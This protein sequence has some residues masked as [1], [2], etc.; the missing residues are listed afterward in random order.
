MSMTLLFFSLG[1]VLALLCLWAFWLAPRLGP[2]R[3]DMAQ[4]SAM[5]ALHTLTAVAI[6]SAGIFYLEEQQW[7]PRLGL[8]LKADA[9]LVP[10]S[11]P[12]SAVIQVAIEITNKT[13]TAQTINH[14]EVS[15]D[16]LR[17]TVRRDPRSPQDVGGVEI[18][19]F[20]GSRP[21]EIGADET[22]HQFVEIPVS[23]E[24]KLVR[25]T[26]YVPK[27]GAGNARTGYERK[28]LVSL[29]DICPKPA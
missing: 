21:V 4:R 6:L 10:D 15:A 28:L 12:A 24:W 23:C 17:G 16:A 11:G 9:K 18:Y 2:Q 26:A 19:R 5:I 14:V 20:I 1:S 27:P 8:D 25:V 29:A 3:L 7:S 22:S 13:E